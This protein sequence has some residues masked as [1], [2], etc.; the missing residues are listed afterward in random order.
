MAAS[1]A[2]YLGIFYVVILLFVIYALLCGDLECGKPGSMRYRIHKFVT[3][4]AL[5]KVWQCF[6]CVLGKRISG[7]LDDTVNYCCY[8]P[9]PFMQ[10][11]YLS[12]VLGGYLLF[13]RDALSHIPNPYLSIYHRM[14]SHLSVFVTISLF[15]M[16]SKA[17]P[18][19]ISKKNVSTFL[20]SFLFDNMLYTSK[21]CRTCLIERP[22]RSKHCSIC[23]IC[24]SRFDHHCPWINNCVGE[25]NL[26]YFLA[27]LFA[28]A[29]L[30]L[31]CFYLCFFILVSKLDEANLFTKTFRNSHTGE[32]TTLPYLVLLQYSVVV[33][34]TI[35]S[36]GMFCGFISLVLYGFLGYHLWLVKQNIT[37]NESYKWYDYRR[38]V[39]KYIIAEKE[40][41]EGETDQQKTSAETRREKKSTTF[42]DKYTST[43]GQVRN[44]RN[45]NV[46]FNSTQD[47]PQYKLD[48]KGHVLIEN[49]YDKGFFSNFYE[50]WSPPSLRSR[51]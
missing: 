32:F 43:S 14:I 49:K 17:N 50:V 6:R 9:N 10:I 35:F 46:E 20:K 11:L 15:L 30:C 21:R 33:G 28:T 2:F 13:L 25:Y 8:K 48:D 29:S 19:K 36:L 38:C 12:L 3:R 39:S 5:A 41:L 24:V 7:K 34:G 1:F 27:F 45:E 26:R 51:V 47:R 44:R 4:D 31:Y 22:A 18:G 42:E 40:L 16:C 37:T 23:G